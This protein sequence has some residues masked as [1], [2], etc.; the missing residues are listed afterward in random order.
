MNEE[1]ET[2]LDELRRDFEIS[3]KELA[4]KQAV[5]NRELEMKFEGLSASTTRQHDELKSTSYAELMKMEQSMRQK[6]E[7]LEIE[8][9]NLKEKLDRIK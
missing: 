3:I 2:K 6:V 7:M 9:I 8:V 1:I 5:S 4:I